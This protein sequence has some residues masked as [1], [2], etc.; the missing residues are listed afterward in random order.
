MILIDAM[1]INDSGGKILL[2]YLISNIE[3]GKISTYYLLDKRM[4]KRHNLISNNLVKYLD[5][6]LHN[7]LWFY[8]KHRNYFTRV[9]CFGNLPP[10]IK[11]SATIF[12]YFH[13]P[14]FLKIPEE[15]PFKNKVLIFA[16]TFVLRRLMKNTNFWLVQSN[17]IKN[18]FISK[19]NLK[20]EKAV[21]VL[22]FYP[23]IRAFSYVKRIKKRFIYVSNGEIHK[24]HE[25]LMQ[26]FQLFY[27]KH[28]I[29]DLHL[30]IGPAYINLID[31]IKELNKKGYPI[32]NHGFIKRNAL[33]KIYHSSEFAIYPSLTESFGLGI[34]EA[35]DCGCKIIGADRPY[36]HA[37]CEPSGLF[38][39]E[40]IG[41]I[42]MAMEKA[43]F[44]DTKPSK[45]LVH[46]EIDRLINFLNE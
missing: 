40:S 25:K 15:V 38:N 46:N 12:T 27:D 9:L 21:F 18:E 16:K 39:P 36:I 19:F 13:Q 6:G 4:Q 34:V 44:E 33:A 5:A 32:K 1:Y 28:S 3:K 41:E 8:F 22:P 7:R 10:M 35:L 20:N 11:L 17:L 24:N 37:I 45:K 23:P 43:V 29:G 2:D 42:V 30:T 26:A 31:K 14:M